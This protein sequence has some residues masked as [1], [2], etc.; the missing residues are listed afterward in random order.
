MTELIDNKEEIDKIIR[1]KIKGKRV[2]FTKHFTWRNAKRGISDEKVKEVFPQFDKVISIEKKKLKFGDWGY[3]LFY[4][5][6]N[7]VTFSIALCPIDN[8]ID[9]IHAIEFKRNLGKR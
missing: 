5:L 6:S 7:N 2:V 9:F 3:E 1:E 4:S 8:R